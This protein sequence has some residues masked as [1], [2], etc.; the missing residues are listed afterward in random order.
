[1][2][3]S[4]NEFEI[5]ATEA[6]IANDARLT[7]TRKSIL[8]LLKKTSRP[9]TVADISNILPEIAQSSLYRNLILLENAG[10]IKRFVTEN[11]FAYYE[12]SEELLGHHHHLRC[13]SCGTVIDIELTKDVEDALHK[14]EK[15]LSKKHFFR[16]IDHHLDFVGQCKN[17][18]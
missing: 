4:P 3:N 16:D 12:L 9:L 18:S 11:E 5:H 10:L 1:M 8:V 7:R 13:S 6:L 17:C 15:T 2:N 14:L